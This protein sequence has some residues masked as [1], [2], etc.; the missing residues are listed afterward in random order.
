MDSEKNCEDWTGIEDRK[1][2]KKVQNRINQRAHRKRVSEKK[3]QSPRSGRRPYRVDRW[4]IAN[5]KPSQ[6]RKTE[7]TSTNALAIRTSSQQTS[8]LAILA[9]SDSSLNIHFPLPADHLLHLIHY[10]VYRALASN[11]DVLRQFARIIIPSDAV[12]NMQPSRQ[13]CGVP[14]VVHPLSTGLPDSLFP[15]SLQ[16]VHPHSNWIDIFPFPQIRDNLIQCEDY[17]DV[18]DFLR[19]LFGDMV[20]DSLS[21]TPETSE[22]LPTSTQMHLQGEDEDMVTA[23][24][25]GLIVWGEPYVKESWEATPGTTKTATS[26]PAI[27]ACI[28]DLDGLLINSEDIITQSTNRLLEKYGRPRPVPRLGQ[29]AHLSRAI[30]PGIKEVHLQFQTCTPL[31]GA[32][33]LLS[34]LSRARSASGDRIELALASSTKTHTFEL[35]MSRPETKQLLNFFPSERRVLGDDPRVRQGRGKPAPDIYLLA[36]QALNSAADSGKP[37]LSS[38]CLVFEDS[39]AGVEAGRRA[40]MRVVWVPHPDLAVEYQ[41]REKDV[42]AGRTGM[43]EI[44][45]EW[46]LGEID[47]GWAESIL[48]LDHFD[49]EKYGIVVQS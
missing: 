10:N 6:P 18:M 13:L 40:G 15:T 5:D 16:M 8:A 20:N 34:K 9:E 3:A 24:R 23:G 1:Q 37:I 27:R 4:R 11:K 32:E 41:A 43:S 44:G 49:Y 26:F 17:V 22:P 29:V 7:W 21:T 28:F 31:P 36:L 45:D 39:V 35:K 12:G 48:S 14:T 47:D 38:E 33:K 2:R 19:D 46:Q 30:R 25:K 42:L